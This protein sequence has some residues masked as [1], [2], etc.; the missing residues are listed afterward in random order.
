MKKLLKLMLV[1]IFMATVGLTLTGC[2]EETVV[3]EDD[4]STPGDMAVA[5]DLRPGN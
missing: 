3:V 5:R 2:P 1:G 4:L